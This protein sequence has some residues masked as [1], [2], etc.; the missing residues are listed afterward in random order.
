MRAKCSNGSICWRRLNGLA[1]IFPRRQNLLAWSAA[2]YTARSSHWGCREGNFSYPA[3]RLVRVGMKLELCHS[4]G[5]VINAQRADWAAVRCRQ[6]GKRNDNSDKQCRET[7]GLH[8]QRKA[9]K[10]TRYLPQSRSQAEGAGH[11]FSREWRQA[12]GGDHLV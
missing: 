9:A 3:M 4:A 12:A 7:R 8:G 10:P 1:E 5:C 2:R 11:D 6:A